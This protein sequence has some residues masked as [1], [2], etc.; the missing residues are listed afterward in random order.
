M[1]GELTV[2]RRGVDALHAG[3]V[4]FKCDAETGPKRGNCPVFKCSPPPEG[5]KMK[6]E[7]KKM[8]EDSCCAVGCNY[9]DAEGKAC[10]PG[11]C[12]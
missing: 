6:T 5:C 7:F 1:C 10:K 2:S 4:P 3:T 8:D 11:Q 12:W 9:V